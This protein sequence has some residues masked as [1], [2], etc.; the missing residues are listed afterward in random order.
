MTEE[1]LRLIFGPTF[2]DQ[3]K[4]YLESRLRTQKL[5]HV[6]NMS[7]PEEYEKRNQAFK[8][9]FGFLGERVHI[10]PPFHCDCGYNISIGEGTFINFNITVLDTG[11]VTIGKNCWIGPNVNIYA[12]THPVN[13]LERRKHVISKP[14]TIGDDVWIGGGAIICPGVTIGSRSVIGA[15]S[16]V[17]HDIPED[18]VAYG[19]PC[20]VHRKADS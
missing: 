13:Y 14:V 9:L 7:S 5:L 3:S 8:E 1:Q 10:E 16:V 18:S 20:K 6:L 11:K 4:E 15:G 2:N 19:N 12:A 17:T